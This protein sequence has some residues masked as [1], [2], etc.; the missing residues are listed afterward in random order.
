MSGGKESVT[1][2]LWMVFTMGVV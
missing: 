2:F 1:V